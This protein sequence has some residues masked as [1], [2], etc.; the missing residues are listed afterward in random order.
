MKFR[1][2]DDN[3]QKA[4]IRCVDNLFRATLET[5]LDKAGIED[6]I[7]LITIFVNAGSPLALSSGS[8]NKESTCI[9]EQECYDTLVKVTRAK[10]STLAY[11]E[12][13]KTLTEFT[14]PEL[15]DYLK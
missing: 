10:A 5:S 6:S 4:L 8:S 13:K 7:G 11:K 1:E 2:L 15:V 12:G 3:D 14:P 9:S